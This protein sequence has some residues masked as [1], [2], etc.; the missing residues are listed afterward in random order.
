MGEDLYGKPG[1]KYPKYSSRGSNKKIKSEIK[2][3]DEQYSER[4]I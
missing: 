4:Q 1:I 2:P 3:S